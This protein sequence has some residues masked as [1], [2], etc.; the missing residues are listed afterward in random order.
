MNRQEVFTKIAK[1]LIKQGKKAQKPNSQVCLYRD[2]E[3]RCAVGCLIP[4]RL[5]SE[6]MEGHDI[7]EPVI[8]SAL[9]KAGVQVVG[10]TATMLGMLQ[11][12]HDT[13]EIA[14]WPEMLEQTAKRFDLKMPRLPK[15]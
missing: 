3:R 7:L 4:D 8:A 2:G 5:Y 13:Y 1:H 12:I 6:E 9:R 15:K 11:R 10:Q 14:E